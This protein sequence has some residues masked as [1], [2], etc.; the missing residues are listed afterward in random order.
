MRL[1][2]SRIPYQDRKGLSVWPNGARMA[3]L[4]YTSPEQWDWSQKEAISAAGTFAAGRGTAPSISTQSSVD[5]GFHVGLPRMRDI[6]A[7]FGM[8][9]TIWTSGR[10]VEQFPDVLRDLVADGHQLN[11]HGYSQGVVMGH[12]DREQQRE[13]ILKAKELVESISGRPAT[14]WVSPAAESNADTIDLLAE[15]GFG[16]HGDLQDDELP[17]FVHTG[18]RTILEIPYRLAGNLNDLPLFTRNVN[19]VSSGIDILTGAFDAYYQAASRTPLLFNYG[20]H[21]YISGRPDT[22]LVLRGFLEHIH[23]YDDVW[24]A[25]YDEVADWWR[26]EFEPKIADGIIDVRA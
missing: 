5:Y 12:L 11:P 26:K 21:P 14:G 2:S 18:G 9:V 17:Y 7:D 25:T 16:Y 24:I 10:S 15:L 4:F 3:V 20:T 19:S 1:T 6:L 13:Q 22:A 23:R 8:K